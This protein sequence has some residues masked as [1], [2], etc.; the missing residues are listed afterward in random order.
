MAYSA[1][2]IIKVLE[3]NGWVLDRIKGS[4]HV[5]KNSQLGK[6]VPI[7]LHGKGELGKGLFFAILKQCGVNKKDLK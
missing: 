3:A 1:K 2:E 5:Y 7:P 4:H 6:S